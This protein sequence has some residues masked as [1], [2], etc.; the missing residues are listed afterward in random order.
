MLQACNA[1][2]RKTG[3]VFFFSF[4][5]E[6]KKMFTKYLHICMNVHMSMRMH[7]FGHLIGSS[8]LCHF[9]VFLKCFVHELWIIWSSWLFEGYVPV[10]VKRRFLIGVQLSRPPI[11]V[12]W[13]RWTTHA[14][15][16][17]SCIAGPHVW[18]GEVMA[19][20]RCKRF[21]V[22][23]V[24]SY[25]HTTG[26]H[27]NVIPDMNHPIPIAQSGY[28]PLYSTSVQ[29]SQLNIK[30]KLRRAGI[31]KHQQRAQTK[32]NGLSTDLSPNIDRMSFL[33][34]RRPYCQ[35]IAEHSRIANINIWKPAADWSIKVAQ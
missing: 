10:D 5:W 3:I 7:S 27:T 4:F 17:C 34:R 18:R 9:V 32:K 2:T 13:L 15:S 16:L 1:R 25:T 11:V 20:Q 19:H 8:L 24:Y 35:E 30:M 21:P 12:P 14:S 33:K 26:I 28:G 31:M 29:L 22:V 23:C 6:G